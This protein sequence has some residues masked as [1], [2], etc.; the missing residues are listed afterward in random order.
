M[1][2]NIT[3]SKDTYI[4]NKIL[5]SRYR[6]TDS[7]VGNAG[8]LDLFKLYNESPLPAL[9]AS[10]QSEI[11]SV[12]LPDHNAEEQNLDGKYFFLYDNL[13]TKYY[14]WFSIVGQ[15]T[16]D[17]SVADTTGIEVAVTSGQVKA[18]IAA[19]LATAVGDVATFST[20]DQGGGE[21]EI[22]VIQEAV[23]LNA[24]NG[25]IEDPGFEI[26]V[27]QQGS[28]AGEFNLDTDGDGTPETSVELSRLLL[29]F[30]ISSLADYQTLDVTHSDF[31]ATLKLYDILDGQM[32]PTNFN[33]E[34]FPLANTFTEGIGRDTGSFSDLDICNFV[35]ASYSSTPVLWNAVGANAKGNVGAEGIDVFVSMSD[36]EGG[37]DQLY[38]SK[39]FIEGTEPFE[40]DVTN[41]VKEMY[42][43]NIPNNG[44]R[45]SFSELEEQDGKTYFLKR[46]ASRHVLNQYLKPRLTIS[47]NDS[48]RDNSK[49]ALF[50]L[51]TTLI[52]QNTERG[53]PAFTTL[54]EKDD[55]TLD[56]KIS[57][58][59]WS[60]TYTVNRAGPYGSTVPPIQIPGMYSSTFT[61]NILDG[62]TPR[63]VS[64]QNEV[65]RV[66]FADHNE[67]S[68]NLIGS[69]FTLASND[70]ATYDLWFG[71]DGDAEPIGL[72]NPTQIIITEGQSANE[73]AATAQG[74]IDGLSG[75]SA[76]IFSLG[77]VHV[78]LDEVGEP[79][80]LASV[81]TVSDDN[82]KVSRYTEGNSITLQEHII[83]SGSINFKTEWSGEVDGSSVLLHTGSL[84]VKTS[85]RSTFNA[86]R[87][88]VVFSLLNAK[89][90][91]KTSEKA[92]LRIFS[93]DL[94]E[95]LKSSK[96]S[97]DI[98]SII[99]DEMYY[100]VRDVSSGDL[101][102]PFES[103]NNG[104]RVSTD[105]AGMYFDIDMSSL[106]A[107]RSYTIDLLIVTDGLEIVYECKNTRFKVEP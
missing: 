7:N 58:G 95:E 88:N 27:V 100:R 30:D 12:S 76:E 47:W 10:K 32:A 5:N 1:Y 59:S 16:A 25:N 28:I 89:S 13:D 105:S 101:I 90:S 39:E 66:E 51:P 33:V 63:V 99:F 83:A 103:Q 45:I 60:S 78:T 4:H 48:F 15:G 75:L 77:V 68:E 38:V 9:E 18:D 81:G 57:T 21:V 35:T 31:T 73:I 97:Y 34:I 26:A 70:P 80:I 92:K 107:G 69:Y 98:E 74:V 55:N 79:A 87:K 56:L 36:G 71:L 8:T 20:S 23:V 82:F 49:N 104:T 22:T 24:S 40:F 44:F 84:K 52:F 11:V 93:R 91:Y 37:F 53:T 86:T 14:V 67:K 29:S 65:I 41:I 64:S 46:F 62:V 19:T 2:L 61:L 43:G 106:F 42:L 85:T 3:A 50:D 54:Y 6:T 102:I 96:I 72:T 94:N 17:P